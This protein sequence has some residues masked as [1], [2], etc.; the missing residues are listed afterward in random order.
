MKF[1]L[2][3]FYLLLPTITLASSL[4]MGTETLEERVPMG[5]R[6]TSREEVL[7]Q[8]VQ[9]AYQMQQR[10]EQENKTSEITSRNMAKS[11][12]ASVAKSAASQYVPSHPGAYHSLMY[13]TP[14][15][16]TVEIED[17][18]VWV[19]AP[20]DLSTVMT[21][22]S[23]DALVLVPNKTLFSSYDF[24]LVNLVTGQSI[25]VILSQAP[26]YNGPY[27]HWIV[28]IDYYRNYVYLE[29][30]SFWNMSSFD[31]DI[32]HQWMVNDTVIIG[33]T[34]RWLNPDMLINVSTLTYAV[35]KATY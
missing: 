12:K 14:A 22:Y 17:G 5:E 20:S 34:D 15:N 1:S 2:K 7:E 26:Y 4:L 27:T 16:L 21:W 13:I 32:V 10:E 33:T 31:S 35:G 11:A 8:N 29:D 9:R 3:S 25:Q 6:T 24:R 18:S 28:A 23:T 19:F 30:G